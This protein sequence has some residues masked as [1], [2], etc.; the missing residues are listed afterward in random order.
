MKNIKKLII[1]L[2]V[3][4]SLSIIILVNKADKQRENPTNAKMARI[5][6]DVSAM[7]PS[8]REK[9]AYEH[10]EKD[11][12]LEEL[13]KSLYAIIY[14][15]TIPFLDEKDINKLNNFTKKDYKKYEKLAKKGDNLAQLIIGDKYYKGIGVEKDFNKAFEYF[16]KAS[17]TQRCAEVAMGNMY[18]K[19]EGVEKDIQKAIDLWTKD[20]YNETYLNESSVEEEEKISCLYA[21]SDFD[22]LI[23]YPI[24]AYILFEELA[25]QGDPSIQTKLAEWYE[26]NTSDGFLS[27]I[28]IY[29]NIGNFRAK[30]WFSKAAKQNYKDAYVGLSAFCTDYYGSSHCE[31]FYKIDSDIRNLAEK[32]FQMG[33]TRVYNTE[34]DYS[35]YGKSVMGGVVTIYYDII[36]D[37]NNPPYWPADFKYAFKYYSKTAEKGDPYGLYHIGLMYDMGYGRDKD[38][39]KALEY[40]QKATANIDFVSDMRPKRMGKM[41]EQFGERLIE[42]GKIKEAKIV[43]NKSIE[44]GNK[45]SKEILKRIE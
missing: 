26:S 35:F 4:V 33:S 24:E 19:G 6:K 27:E 28:K 13:E 14:S 12:T 42:L 25:M 1:L 11:S 23:T 9:Y 8:E 38:P 7:S 39:K 10:Y 40:Y 22:N 29:Q 36:G 2:I 21:M 16:S 32:A 30:Y 41:Y 5:I 45:K 3:V 17:A 34:G 20:F 18:F 31:D 15:Q 44:L 43:L 37:E